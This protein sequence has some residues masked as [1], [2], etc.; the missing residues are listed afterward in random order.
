MAFGA[1]LG[2]FLALNL[3]VLVDG[4]LRPVEYSRFLELVEQGRVERVA[5]STDQVTGFYRERSDRVAFVTTRPPETDDRQLV[6]L[7]RR[8]GVEFTGSRPSGFARFI[9]TFVPAWL[10]PLALIIG[11]WI[12]FMR[13]FRPGAGAMTF[14]RARHKIY[15]REDLKTGFP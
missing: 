1:L 10:L 7:L 6:P 11:L 5:I 13:R 15:D 8:E 12:F 4:P 14:G 3:L 9:E 2:L